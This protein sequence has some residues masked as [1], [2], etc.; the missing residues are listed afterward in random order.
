M[1]S[2]GGLH[3]LGLLLHFWSSSRLSSLFQSKIGSE[4]ALGRHDMWNGFADFDS[5]GHSLQNKLEQRGN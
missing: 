3:Q 1:A 4:G 2:L 5:V